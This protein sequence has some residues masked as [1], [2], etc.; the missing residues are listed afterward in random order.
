MDQ[1]VAAHREITPGA[2]VAPIPDWVDPADYT[3][4]ATANPHFI[5]HG[6][7]VLL[8]DTQIDL[9]GPERAW[10]S[11]RA[12]LVTAAAGA[13]HV[14]QFNV[15]FD[16]HF[17]QIEVHTI[18][19]IRNGQ[20]TE[21]TPT[22]FFEVMRRERNMERLQFDGRLTI[23]FTLPDVRQGDVVETA[24]TL[25]G[26]RKSLAG[27]QSAFMGLEWPV[28]IV[29][30]RVRQ[31]WPESRKIEERR[32]G[33]VPEPTET[34]TD[35][36]IDRRWRV[37]ERAGVRFEPLS[38]PWVLQ[39]A[40]L[41]LT[42]WRDWA[43]VADAFT[44]LYEQVGALP[45]E[46]EQEIARIAAA[47]PT[48]AGRASAIL[49]FVQTGMR[50]L[51]ISIGEG[52]YAPRQFADVW[53]TRYGDCKDKSNLYAHMALRLG[54]NACPALV[55]TFDGYALD[56]WMPSPQTFDHCIVRVEVDGKIY[57]LDA[58][59]PLQPSPL[60]KIG[61]SYFGW[62]LPLRPGA[63]ALER[64][65]DPPNELLSETK[66]NIVLGDRPE[67][68][69][70]YEWIH[71]FR[72]VRAEGMREQ[73]ERDGAV[74]VFKRYAEE[75][76][77]AWPK[78]AVVTQEIVSDDIATN[79][80]V[81]R[82]CYDIADAWTHVEGKNW[83]FATR[84][85]SLVGSLAPLDAGERKH[86]IYLG[87][88]GR[89]SRRVELRTVKPHEGGWLREHRGTTLAYVDEM[90]V[91]EPRLL[92]LEQMLSI[93]ALTLPAAEAELYRKVQ[94]DLSGNELMITESLS[95]GQF[96]GG[97]QKGEQMTFWGTARWVL[98]GLLIIYWVSRFAAGG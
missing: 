54:V 6:I 15:S 32:Y 27:R 97:L 65:A 56:D 38:P 72:G 1:Q 46:V 36:I 35:G 17:E 69:V 5:A 29:D 16:P 98:I 59:R 9:C 76:Q 89:R 4:P 31:R 74:S 26:M 71:T 24:Y 51:A 68:P 48:Q 58:T 86:D 77:R 94:T 40:A 92:V 75:L 11:R 28:G 63:N 22:A 19:V 14:A 50:Y 83:R 3:I 88:P 96:V 70:R 44:P 82:E 30:V 84:D 52:G 80:I 95:G 62:A 25:Y 39:N 91:V 61:Q 43:E 21:H 42:E 79:T 57:W 60:D 20:R 2:K 81:V 73:L 10:F 64:M 7:C 66:E 87:Q 23:H 85:L 18:A 45:D 34:V 55:N 41:Q 67:A 90:R 53:S 47:E 78:A 37:F 12:E 33:A 8:H 93:K 13:E 49:R